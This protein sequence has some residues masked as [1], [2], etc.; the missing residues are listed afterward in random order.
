MEEKL[1]RS[2]ANDGGEECGERG[3]VGHIGRR[4]EVET[5]ARVEKVLLGW[6]WKIQFLQ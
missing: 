4:E 3:L 2:T 1:R 6:M 5:G